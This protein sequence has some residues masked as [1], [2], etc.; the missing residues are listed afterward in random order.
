[1]KEYDVCIIGGGAAGLAAAASLDRKIKLCIL[2]KNEIPGRK[3]MATGGGRCNITNAA[4]KNKDL[5]LDFFESL[6]MVC[7]SDSEGRYYP[8][9]GYAPDVVKILLG[10]VCRNDTA[11]A[12]AEAGNVKSERPA[13]E[14]ITS[15]QAQSIETENGSFYIKFRDMKT[16]QSCGIKAADVIIACGGK[17]APQFGTT[18]DGYALAKSLGH[19]ITRLYPVLTAVECGDFRSI[20]GVRAKGRA[21]IYRDGGLLYEED[22]E[23]QFTADGVS[24]ICIF[25]LTPYI[26]ANDGESFAEALK[27]FE[28][29]I[30]LAPDIPQ[31]IITGRQSSF[32]ILTE[33]LSDCVPPDRVKDWRLPVKGVKGWKN[34][35]CTAGGVAAE[36][37]DMNTM[38]SKLVEGLYF[39]GEVIDLQGPC[40]GYNLQNA[41]ETGIKAARAVNAKHADNSN[42]GVKAEE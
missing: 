41:W 42:R 37:I 30:D 3:I 20:K 27:H 21:G 26:R 8:Y 7:R 31:E 5:T 28:L 34:A 39:A 38:E 35:Q 15:A 25:N 17:A 33:K 36:E 19:S 14:I 24:G 12:A 32:G 40:G 2:E 11:D 18:G 13:A 9:S 10:A 23:I 4:C 1:M 6:G 16:K 22:G 29:R